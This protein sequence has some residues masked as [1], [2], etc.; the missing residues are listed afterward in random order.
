VVAAP[1]LAASV[2]LDVASALIARAAAPAFVQQLLAPLRSLLLLGIT[3][4]LLERMLVL[5]SGFA[6]KLP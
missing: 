3:A 2:V 4:L 6:A 5:L 1:V